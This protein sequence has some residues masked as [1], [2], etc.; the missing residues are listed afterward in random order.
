MNIWETGSKNISIERSQLMFWISILGLLYMIS[1]DNYLLFHSLVELFSILVAYVI[2]LIVWKSRA[3]LENRYLLL[4]GIAYFFVGSFDLLHTLAY[5]GMG[6]FPGYGS[7]LATQLW[8]A[9]RY[10]ESISLLAAP[11]LSRRI[12]GPGEEETKTLENVLI[13]RKIFLIYTLIAFFLLV[14]IFACRNFPECYIEG[15]GLTPFKVGSEYVISFILFCSL[16]LL[17]TK[18]DMFEPHIFRMLAA[19]VILTIFGEL[20]FT[21]YIDVY[22]FSNLVGHYFKL[23]SFYIIYKAIV[24]TGF[25][26][27]YSILFRELKLSEEAFREQAIALHDD[28]GLIYSMLG[29]KKDSP[30]QETVA[31]NLQKGEEHYRSFMQNFQGIGFQLDRN[32]VPVF[33]HGAVEEVTGYT[34]EDF[35]SMKI[36]WAEIIT[37]E[38]QP[39][40]LEKR[41]NVSSDP[42][43]ST[44]LEYRIRKKEGEIRWVREIIRKLPGNPGNR[45]QFQG[46]V[47]DIT[48][49]KM[50][51]EALEKIDKIRTKEIHHRIKNNLQVISSLLSLQAEKFG[52]EEVLEAFRESQN[53]VI[54]MALIHE[55]LYKGDKVDTLDFAAYLR[56]LAPDLL[57]S[58]TV[59]DDEISLKLDLEKVYLGMDSA[60]PLGIIVN[61]LVSNSLKH[62]FP[63]KRG[64][65]SIKLKRTE[66][67]TKLAAFAGTGEECGGCRKNKNTF[68]LVVSDNGRGIPEEIDFR[69]TD[70][71][72][73]QLV[74]LLVEQIEGSIELNNGI[75]TEFR[76]DFT[77]N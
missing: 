69:D 31:E 42:G 71:L 24:E 60:I 58:Y 4:I 11:L 27:P 2:F 77:D 16:L 54:S 62:A 29:V 43:L 32:F 46:S 59:G 50:A 34:R 30:E 64:E 8:I 13:S 33:L 18:K 70:S 22:G 36:D 53:R 38:D 76:I 39:L 41:E 5:K 14:S 57:T 15:S 6:V 10:I 19:S 17:N 51:E 1:L 66:N 47:Y 68:T 23:L 40:F 52:D 26:N 61:E 65:I 28:Q 55:E 37:R 49:R 25:E 45:G 48:E 9:S 74:N 3:L 7:N 56:K 72:G 73:L 67:C 63:T 21:F 44:E 12:S 20:A 35:L 75:G